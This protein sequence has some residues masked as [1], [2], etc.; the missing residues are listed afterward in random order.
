M[1]RIE[2][3]VLVS[4]FLVGTGVFFVG[5]SRQVALAQG[6]SAPIK[7]TDSQSGLGRGIILYK[8]QNTIIGLEGQDDWSARVFLMN[9]NA[10]SWAE[11][12]MTGVPRGYLWAYPAIDQSS[13]KM[14]FE[15]GYIE[16]DKLIMN[17]L[18]GR[19]TGSMAVRDA[20]EKK[21]LTDKKT[22]FGETGSNVWLN[23]PERGG[24]TWPH[25]GL[26]L[27]SGADL[28]IPYCV[29]ASTYSETPETYQGKTYVRKAYEDGPFHNG[30]FH[31]SDSGTTWQIQRISDFQSSLPSIC[32]SKD[33]YYYF[34]ASLARN[35]GRGFELWFSRKSV[36][37]GS[38]T[39][40]EVATK[41]FC[42]SG[43][44]WKYI[45]TAEND[46][47]H[48][49]WLDRRHEKTRPY[50]IDPS[51]RHNCQNYEVAYCHRKDSDTGWS[52]D[53]ILSAGL[54]YSFAPVMSV[55]GDRIVVAWAGVQDDKDGHDEF[56]PN[57]IY[58]VTSKDG[59]KTWTQPLR[60]TDNIKAGITAG[61]PQVALLNGI[62]H[63]LY[64]QGKISYKEESHGLVKL[65]QPPWPIYYQQ[66]VFPD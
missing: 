55:E 11:V 53:I 43:L 4:C 24:R 61:R 65:N 10:S 38:W 13:D 39:A 3:T 40:P 66:R 12:Q 63:L 27:I 48:V 16:N 29:H 50:S 62:I 59:G 28:H 56:W 23:V 57:D 20:V 51:G 25:L 17:V 14:F 41:T 6:W 45:A 26:G 30:V 46:T 44:S 52:K 37:G 22:L 47:V 7:V 34:A 58:Y 15:Q 9:P 35:L 8:W 60:V 2:Y 49:C 5:C 33:Y 36:E 32:R 18:L 42:D 54:L 31:S 1:K 19:M 21:W 64:S